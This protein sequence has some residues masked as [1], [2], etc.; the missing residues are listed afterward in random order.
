M[1]MYQIISAKGID[2][3]NRHYVLMKCK[4]IILNTDY[5]NE[6]IWRTHPYMTFVLIVY[7]IAIS[8]DVIQGN[9]FGL[10]TLDFLVSSL[11]TLS[12]SYLRLCAILFIYLLN[13]AIKQGLPFQS[14]KWTNRWAGRNEEWKIIK[15]TKFKC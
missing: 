1:L 10:V 11:F 8:R 14:W 12:K 3:R 7:I 5:Q 2:W 9:P 13:F 6:Y 15:E 4:Q